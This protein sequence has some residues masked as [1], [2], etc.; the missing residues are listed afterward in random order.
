MASRV[1][2][3]TRFDLRIDPEVRTTIERAAKLSGLQVTSFLLHAAIEKAR[4]IIADQQVIALDRS[5]ST[6]F[7]RLMD[8]DYDPRGKMAT[9]LGGHRKAM[10]KLG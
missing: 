5:A 2:P 9:F 1:Q 8:S 6:R 10:P 4:G 3:K 7:Q